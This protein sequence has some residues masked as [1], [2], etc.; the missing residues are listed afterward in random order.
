[1]RANA[2]VYYA[3]ENVFASGAITFEGRPETD[4]SYETF[5]GQVTSEFGTGV[6]ILDVFKVVVAG[7]VDG[8]PI[9]AL[10]PPGE[11]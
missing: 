5:V 8:E 1:M 3:N 4:L 6:A 2:F 10:E 11:A 7:R 9:L